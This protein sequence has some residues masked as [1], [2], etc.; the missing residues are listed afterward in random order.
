MNI[1]IVEDEVKIALALKKGLE[2]QGYQIDLAFDGEEG[3]QKLEYNIYDLL[4]LDINLPKKNGLELC[5][6]IRE[7]NNPIPIIMLTAFNTMET[8]LQG[9]DNGAD[10]YISKP[11]EFKELVV[12][13][14]SL[15]KRVN[16]SSVREVE[17][18]KI[19]DLEMNMESREVKRGDVIINLTIKEFQ[20]LEYFLRNINK[21]LS[22]AEIAKSVWDIDFDT[23]TNVIDV[24]VNYLRNK[25]DKD[26][27]TKLLHTKIG[28]GYILKN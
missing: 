13:I 10:D 4:I 25:I 12:R 5:K 23:Q 28:A 18:L 17:I 1:L 2:E 11:F 15:L 14:R 7:K 22:R 24:Y 27:S 20:L 9:F 26:F 21:V 19:G 8:K 16:K 3:G 6:W